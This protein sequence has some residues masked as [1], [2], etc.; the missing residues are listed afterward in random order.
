MI[1]NNINNCQKYY[2]DKNIYNVVKEKTPNF[3]FEDI[4]NILINI[5]PSDDKKYCVWIF[6]Q[7]IK[8]QFTLDEEETVRENISKFLTENPGLILQKYN[9]NEIKN[10]KPKSSD[11]CQT[12]YD[13]NKKKINTDNLSFE[14]VYNILI[15]ISEDKKYCTWIIDQY[16]EG[17]FKLDEA[18]EVKDNLKFYL[19]FSNRKNVRP[20]D[21][22][23]TYSNMVRDI[24]KWKNV[25]LENIEKDGAIILYDGIYGQ[26]VSPLTK[27]A[28]CIYG[29]GTKWCTAGEN[30]NKFLIYNSMGPLFIWK[31]GKTGNKYQFHFKNGMF[32]DEKDEDIDDEKLRCFIEDDIVISILFK[33]M[34]NLKN[35]AFAYK[36]AK[37]LGK[38]IKEAEKNI[39][40]NEEYIIDYTRDVIK[41]RWEE[42]EK[43]ILNKFNKDLIDLAFNYAI[44]IIK[45][46]WKELEDIIL[47]DYD[48]NIAIDY[49]RDVIKGRWK[50]LE[51]II[52]DTLDNKD[53]LELA[54]KYEE[55]IMKGK[56]EELDNVKIERNLLE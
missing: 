8:K 50:E 28:S 31:D 40:I 25:E 2:Y 37:A 22:N 6:N 12:Y 15:G 3:S 43:Y 54:N 29:K 4:Y 10:F 34:M 17:Y 24:K 11:K 46:R 51:D 30:D 16:I 56:W 47:D 20:L 35:P 53:D 48:I 38:R 1:R 14:E 27:D 55:D 26:L 42:A 18:E 32:M 23:Y 49:A 45:G 19:K 36:Y 52:L 21:N 9:Y 13:K 41:G 39:I 7:Y 5:D 44:H 33:K